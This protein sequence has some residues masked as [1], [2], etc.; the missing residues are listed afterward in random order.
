[1]T[2][3][4]APFTIH[5][6]AGSIDLLRPSTQAPSGEETLDITLPAWTQAQQAEIAPTP[7]RTTDA[8]HFLHSRRTALKDTAHA[9]YQTAFENANPEQHDSLLQD[10][11]QQHLTLTEIDRTALRREYN[12]RFGF[13]IITRA[14]LRWISQT[15]AGNPPRD[16]RRQRLPRKRAHQP[17]RGHHPHRTPSAPGAEN[18]HRIPMAS[19]PSVDILSITG[20]EAM[21]LHPDHNVLWSWPD[22]NAEYTHH[23]LAQFKGRFLVY[24]G[25][26]IY[27]NTG[28]RMFHET[29]E[30]DYALNDSFQIPTSPGM[31]DRIVLYQRRLHPQVG[32]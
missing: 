1:M 16:R 4:P 27:G 7:H 26:D 23:T 5:T 2:T 17:R 14:A 8:E 9:A 19:V 25:E 20:A 32:T 22:L 11:H 29:L 6:L 31:T 28:S 3:A 21:A 12:A 24:I 30:T 18:G 10:L 13:P 15:T